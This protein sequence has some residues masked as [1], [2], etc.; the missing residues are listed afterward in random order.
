MRFLKLLMV[1]ILVTS[2]VVE[3]RI[4]RWSYT[5]EWYHEDDS[6]Y[7]VYKTIYGRRY[8]IVINEEKLI[9]E[10]RYLKTNTKWN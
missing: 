6:R 5:N 8:I 2:C 1:V 10:R 4:H 9:L 7:Q 3:Q